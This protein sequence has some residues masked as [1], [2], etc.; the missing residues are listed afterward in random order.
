MFSQTLLGGVIERIESTGTGMAAEMI[1][2]AL[3]N[4]RF[5]GGKG[6]EAKLDNI[7]ATCYT[8]L[9]RCDKVKA[10]GGSR[11]RGRGVQDKATTTVPPTIAADG[12]GTGSGGG[13]AA[14]TD[15]D[16]RDALAAPAVDDTAAMERGRPSQS[17]SRKRGSAEL[18]RQSSA[19]GPDATLP[20]RVTRHGRNAAEESDGGKGAGSG[21][22]KRQRSDGSGTSDPES[23]VNVDVP[24]TGPAADAAPTADMA[25]TTATG[26]NAMAETTAPQP[27]TPAAHAIEMTGTMIAIAAKLVCVCHGVDSCGD[28]SNWNRVLCRCSRCGTGTSGCVNSLSIPAPLHGRSKC[29]RRW[30]RGDTAPR[31]AGRPSVYGPDHG[32]IRRSKARCYHQRRVGTFCNTHMTYATCYTLGMFNHAHLSAHALAGKSDAWRSGCCFGDARRWRIGV[33]VRNVAT[34][35]P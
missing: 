29:G 33:A 19:P 11:L 2:A 3:E 25:V 12:D 31:R 10:A 7:I 5:A 27:V 35:G 17:A 34:D 1:Q 28:D 18:E 26:E 8:T 24:E 23:D 22:A 13:G 6:H 9:T 20:V 4:A 30:R 32:D 16:D 15:R 21:T 14:T